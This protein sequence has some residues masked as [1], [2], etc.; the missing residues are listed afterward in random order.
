MALLEVGGIHPLIERQLELVAARDIDGL[1]DT[2]HPDAVGLVCAGHARGFRARGVVRGPEQIRDFFTQYTNAG[3]EPLDVLE[4]VEGPD[5]IL[6]R[7]A[8]R[9]RGEKEVGFGAIVVRDG[10]IWR[11]GWGIEGDMPRGRLDYGD[12]PS[13]AQLDARSIDPAL[14]RQIEHLNEQTQTGGQSAA[15]GGA[16]GMMDTV[17]PEAVVVLGAGVARGFRARGFLQGADEISDFLRKYQDAGGEFVDMK[18]YVRSDDAAL[19]RGVMKSRG[20]VE[21]SFGFYVL[22]DGKTWRSVA[23]I[24]GGTA[25]KAR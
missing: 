20:V 14:E 8:V 12:A 1:M 24:E 18:E 6:V 16:D 21:V 7:T 11:F 19:V 22:R 17:H 10:K 2:Y 3:G 15:T 13:V 25:R 5:A 4:Y 23:G 9:S